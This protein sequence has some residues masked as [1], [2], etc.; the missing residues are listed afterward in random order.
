MIQINSR[1]ALNV[2]ATILNGSVF[3][4][5]YGY[6]W[7]VLENTE[8]W[9]FTSGIMVFFLTSTSMKNICTALK[10]KV[11]GPKTIKE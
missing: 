4:M 1:V 10:H 7:I 2:V 5:G 11:K 9:E 8:G 3:P 6:V